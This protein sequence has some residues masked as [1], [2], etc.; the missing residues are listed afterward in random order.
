MLWSDIF[1]YYNVGFVCTTSTCFRENKTT[2][3]I[4]FPFQLL[5]FHR[6]WP[7]AAR[8]RKGPTKPLMVQLSYSTYL[9]RS[10]YVSRETAGIHIVI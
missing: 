5:A 7:P 10:Y 3:K 8:K 9:K 2:A 6:T 1:C 4:Y